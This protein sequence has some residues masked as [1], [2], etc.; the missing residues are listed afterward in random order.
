MLWK[1]IDELVICAKAGICDKDKMISL[2][3]E[4]VPTY[5]PDGDGVSINHW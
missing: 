3:K 2:L 4:I 1:T 5:K